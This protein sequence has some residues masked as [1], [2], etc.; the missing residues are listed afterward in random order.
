MSLLLG[1]KPALPQPRTSCTACWQTIAQ[2]NEARLPQA[3]AGVLG[4]RGS[5]WSA[6]AF[7]ELP[8]VLPIRLRDSCARKTAQHLVLRYF[9]EDYVFSYINSIPDISPDLTGGLV[10]GALAWRRPGPTYGRL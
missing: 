1:P 8:V 2:P 9:L 10:V 6:H 3:A 4:H 5:C 7:D